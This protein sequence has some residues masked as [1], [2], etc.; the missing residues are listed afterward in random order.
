MEF[1]MVGNINSLKQHINTLRVGNP[2]KV[3]IIYKGCII[4]LS[5]EY[6][7]E[8]YTTKE[9]KTNVATF[10]N[11]EGIKRTLNGSLTDTEYY[12]II[13]SNVEKMIIMK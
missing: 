5:E 13:N 11:N 10:I 4:R 1:I 3:F 9:F 12:I 6:A 8:N 2:D 7:R